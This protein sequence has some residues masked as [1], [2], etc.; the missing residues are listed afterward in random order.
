M[1]GGSIITSRAVVGR[2]LFILF[3]MLTYFTAP[4]VTT[5]L[6]GISTWFTP[7]FDDFWQWGLIAIG[8]TLAFGIIAWLVGMFKGSL[9]HH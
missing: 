8:V 2:C 5:T 1:Q 4:A 3:I 6:S 9:R 7:L